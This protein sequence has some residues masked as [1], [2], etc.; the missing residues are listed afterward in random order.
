MSMGMSFSM[1]SFASFALSWG[2]SRPLTADL[3]EKVPEPEPE[4]SQIQTILDSQQGREFRYDPMTG[5]S[6]WVRSVVDR[7]GDLILEYCS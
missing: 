5:K 2:T 6:A 1:P 3:E 7:D 4:S